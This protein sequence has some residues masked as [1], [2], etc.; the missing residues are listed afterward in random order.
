MLSMMGFMGWMYKFTGLFIFKFTMMNTSM[1]IVLLT[2]A[3]SDGDHILTR[4]FSIKSI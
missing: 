1:P 2:I 4:F 3:I